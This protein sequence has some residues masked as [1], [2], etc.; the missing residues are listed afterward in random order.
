MDNF[1]NANSNSVMP[2]KSLSIDV[3]NKKNRNSKLKSPMFI[4]PPPIIKKELSVTQE[5]PM[6]DFTVSDVTSENDGKLVMNEIIEDART[7]SLSS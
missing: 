6:S 3:R 7:N 1:V 4:P 5:R 2:R